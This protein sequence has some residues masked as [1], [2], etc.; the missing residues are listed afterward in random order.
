MAR[1]L[2]DRVVADP[3]SDKPA[4]GRDEMVRLW[5][6]A[7]AA[8]F[9]STAQLDTDHFA[10]ALVL[11][12]RDADMLLLAGAFHETLAAPA[13][14]DVMA[15]ARLPDGAKFRIGS[16]RDELQLARE[17]FER[18]LEI[19]PG[20]GEARI[21]L[22]HVLGRLG[23]APDA[24]DHLTRAK[25]QTSEPLLRYF[26]ELLLGRET[27]AAGRRAEAIAAYER[28]SA[29]YPRAQSPRLALSE[30][31]AR[32]GERNAAV[33]AAQAVLASQPDGSVDPWWSY[34]ASAGRS[35]SQPLRELLM[36]FATASPSGAVIR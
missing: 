8:H 15:G 36:Q 4:P 20:L 2:L 10:R 11:F 32:R 14:R 35:A 33:A 12:P 13:V 18:A 9:M 26:A 3:E 7:M 28:A 30:L 31:A 21:R 24:I 1:A 23:R 17:L 6:R 27:D 29:I 25:S 34:Y 19:A 16:E 22:G 5:Y